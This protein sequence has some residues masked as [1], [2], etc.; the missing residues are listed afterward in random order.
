MNEENIRAIRELAK[1]VLAGKSRS[2]VGAAHELS[3]F[4]LELFPDDESRAEIPEQI[5]VDG[6]VDQRGVCF[7]GKATKR[8]NGMWQCLANVGGALCIV[9]VRIGFHVEQSAEPR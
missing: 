4:L 6:I 9:E 3:E 2:L 8:P 7:I 1:T 5:D